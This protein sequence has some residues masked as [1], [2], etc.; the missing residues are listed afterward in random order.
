MIIEGKRIAIIGNKE[1]FRRFQRE[2][3][4]KTP[5]INITRPEQTF[6][7]TFDDLITLDYYERLPD[8]HDIFSEIRLRLRTE[9]A[10]V[11]EKINHLIDKAK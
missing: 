3:L 1:E 5:L 8:I 11:I 4:V 9:D 7:I 10:S 6:G 2:N